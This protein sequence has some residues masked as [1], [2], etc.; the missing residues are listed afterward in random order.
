MWATDPRGEL[1]C[2]TLIEMARVDREIAS[3]A[4]EVLRRILGAVESG[5]LT[6]PAAVIYRLEGAAIA[7]ERVG[8]GPRRLGGV[9]PGAEHG[10]DR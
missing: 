3:E 6:G 10:A 4:A 5:G 2:A 7:L 8:A 9:L 1:P